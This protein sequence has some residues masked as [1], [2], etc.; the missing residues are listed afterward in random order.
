V[1]RAPN[2]ASINAALEEHLGLALT[3][4]SLENIKRCVGDDEFQTIQ[5]IIAFASNQEVWLQANDLSAAADT[6]SG[7][8]RQTYPLLS[9]LAVF[10]IIGQ[11][12]YGWR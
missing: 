4:V 12:T 5:E 3:G 8:L 10:R 7:R 2:Y 6:V 11:A 1:A 9:E